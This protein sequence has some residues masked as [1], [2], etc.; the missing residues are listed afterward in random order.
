MKNFWS[1]LLTSLLY[2]IRKNYLLQ[3]SVIWNISKNSKMMLQNGCSFISGKALPHLWNIAWASTENN[4]W[5]KEA[6]QQCNLVFNS[7]SY[8]ARHVLTLFV[9]VMLLTRDIR[10]NYFIL[11]ILSFCMCT[12]G[13]P[14]Y[15]LLLWKWKRNETNICFIIKA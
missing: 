3:H 6:G 4:A 10:V 9:I 1:F 14:I 7:T 5:N 12:A 13:T 8:C 11:P 15:L 2:S